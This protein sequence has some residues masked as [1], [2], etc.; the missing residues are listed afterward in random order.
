M[1]AVPLGADI[2]GSQVQR[3]PIWRVGGG[4][5]GI[6]LQTFSEV[7]HHRQSVSFIQ[8]HMSCQVLSP[9]NTLSGFGNPLPL[10]NPL[11]LQTLPIVTS[12]REPDPR[13]YCYCELFCSETLFQ[14][15]GAIRF[16]LRCCLVELVP[17]AS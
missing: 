6:T 3:L 16:Y 11:I 2:K 14:S 13:T 15:G 10:L 4:P 8:G 17:L 7:D 9:T 12:H 1:C 5:V